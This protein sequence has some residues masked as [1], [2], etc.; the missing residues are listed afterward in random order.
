MVG[1]Q[2]ENPVFLNRNDV[3]CERGIWAQ[4]EVYGKWL[5]YISEGKY[6]V[7]FR[8]IQPVKSGG[9]MVLETGAIINQMK[10]NSSETEIIEMKNV[11]LPEMD[12]ELIPFYAVNGKNI[13]PFW[14]EVERIF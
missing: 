8:F 13:F 10:Y 3:D 2:N 14:V 11:S 4:E 9:Q 6:N 7:R 5:V 12:C 1:N